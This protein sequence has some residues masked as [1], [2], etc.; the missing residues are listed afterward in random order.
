MHFREDVMPETKMSLPKNGALCFNVTDAFHEWCRAILTKLVE[1]IQMRKEF[2]LIL[3][4]FYSCVS[5]IP[6]FKEETSLKVQSLEASTQT[7][8]EKENQFLDI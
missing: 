1:I 5:G 8:W 3:T 6:C 4:I 2:F 7:L